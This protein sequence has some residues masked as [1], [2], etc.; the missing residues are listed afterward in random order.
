MKTILGN[1]VCWSPRGSGAQRQATINRHY[2]PPGRRAAPPGERVAQ[3]PRAPAIRRRRSAILDRPVKSQATTVCGGSGAQ[4]QAN[5]LVPA[6]TG[7]TIYNQPWPLI[8][9]SDGI[10]L[11]GTRVSIVFLP[12]ADSAK[13]GS[14]KLPILFALDS[15]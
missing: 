15:N 14:A 13:F 4:R 2:P 8:L 11:K 6:T 5:M 12:P 7:E 9:T 10:P 1:T 3:H